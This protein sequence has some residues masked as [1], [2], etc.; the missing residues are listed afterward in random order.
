MGS[1]YLGYLT[2]SLQDDWWHS[3]VT[4]GCVCS[5]SAGA[6]VSP[7][8]KGGRTEVNLFLSKLWM[9]LLEAG[10]ATECSLQIGNHKYSVWLMQST[11]LG[12]PGLQKVNLFFFYFS[13]GFWTPDCWKTT[14]IPLRNKHNPNKFFYEFICCISNERFYAKV[15]CGFLCSVL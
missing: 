6:S 10:I 14:E 15:V 1:C 3:V 7:G 2:F 9:L 4:D 5:V 8:G 13:D 12:H 11:T